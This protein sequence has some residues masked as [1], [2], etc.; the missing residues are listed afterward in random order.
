MNPGERNVIAAS[1]STG[2]M[3]YTAVAKNNQIVGNYIGTN[4][5][6]TAKLGNT[7]NGIQIDGASSNYVHHNLLSGNGRD[8]ILVINSGATL[9]LIQKN[10]IGVNAGGTGRLGNGWYGVEVSQHDNTVG[11]GRGAGNVVS[12]NGYGGVVLYLS[13]AYGNRVQGNLIG[14]DKNGTKDLGN[15]GRGLELT[16]G[17]HD[18]RVGGTKGS[19]ANTI[20]GNDLGGVG[21][22]SGS[23]NN[24]IQRNNIGTTATGKGSLPNTGAGLI[25]TDSAGMNYVGGGK[26]ANIIAYN[27][28]YGIVVSKG[29]NATLGTNTIHDNAKGTILK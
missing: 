20:S 1:G 14:T 4:A 29:S 16:N 12:A 19:E 21:I 27:T 7:T 10:L 6:G 28:D 18:N 26:V 24:L 13:T 2:V 11:G 9:N 25:L 22:Y 8:G 15:I 17:A 5:A 3:C 23:K